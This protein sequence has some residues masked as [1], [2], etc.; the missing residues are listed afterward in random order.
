MLQQLKVQ[1]VK[2]KN[3]KV[4]PTILNN[5]KDVVNKTK[6]KYD[7]A[8]EAAGNVQ[9]VVNKLTAQIEEKTVGKMKSLDKNLK[10]AIN[11][12]AKCKTEITRLTVGIKTAER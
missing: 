9:V 6:I 1:E 7:K 5:L 8:S 4:N 12:I 10:D 11:Q 3:T 2:A